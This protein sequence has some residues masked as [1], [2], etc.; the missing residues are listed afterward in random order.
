MPMPGSNAAY[1]GID[2][3]Y[4]PTASRFG[5][6]P[7]HQASLSANDVP[8]QSPT[9]NLSLQ[10]SALDDGGSS[11]AADVAD[12]LAYVENTD[13]TQS[14]PMQPSHQQDLSYSGLPRGAAPPTHELNPWE[15]APASH[16]REP[17]AS[18]YD[19]HQDEGTSLAYASPP[20]DNAGLPLPQQ[21]NHVHFRQQEPPSHA[22]LAPEP[23]VEDDE[24]ARNAAAAREVARE[25]DMLTFSPPP[26][27]PP[28]HP[29]YPGYAGADINREPSPLI[30]PAPPFAQDQQV[31]GG[32]AQDYVGGAVPTAS[33]G[34]QPPSPQ[35]S[36]TS[37]P[38]SPTSHRARPSLGV[39]V[40]SPSPSHSYQTSSGGYATPSE[41][42]ASQPIRTGSPASPSILS[43]GGPRTISAAAFKRPGMRS[44]SSNIGAGGAGDRDSRSLPDVSPLSLRKKVPGSPLPYAG[45]A[46]EAGDGQ[47]SGNPGQGR[48][49]TDTQAPSEAAPP[50]SELGHSG[51]QVA[52]DL[53]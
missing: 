3:N 47:G 37:I 46:S 8:P 26:G 13:Q 5:T 52:D 48:R 32:Q 4:S 12:A 34:Q 43:A 23:E 10:P 35:P 15:N 53:R 14:R 17:N 24:A 9:Q 6:F 31:Y 20:Q 27:P 38:P 19:H 51:G 18:T 40:Y 22:P 2:S 39:N 45:P 36:H 1:A 44:T 50:Y 49:S 25:M 29:A 16:M 41:I 30:P 28:G 21:E 33:E 11:F 7:A 42:P